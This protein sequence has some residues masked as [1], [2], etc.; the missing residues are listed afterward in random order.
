MGICGVCKYLR[1]EFQAS[2]VEPPYMATLDD[3]AW[4][5]QLVLGRANELAALL[6]QTMTLQ[7][8]PLWTWQSSYSSSQ[9]ILGG[10]EH[11]ASYYTALS[12]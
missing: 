6:Q 5:T 10:D 12:L 8:H 2:D 7:G 11:S 4:G 9:H 3:T 1:S